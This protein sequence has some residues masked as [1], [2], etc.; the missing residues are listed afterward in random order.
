MIAQ[1]QITQPVFPLSIPPKFILR[2]DLTLEIRSVIV[3]QAYMAQVQNT[4]GV[5]TEL[6][7][8]YNVSRTFIYSLL[9]TFKTEFAH[10]FFPKEAPASLSREEVEARI[11]SYRFEGRCS[12]DAISTL[13]NR[14]D[15][16]FSSQGAVSEFLTRTGELLPNTLENESEAVRLAVFANDEVFTKSQP[17]LITIEPVSSAILRIELADNRKG[18]QW[19]KHYDDI[20][21][22]GFNPKLLTSDAGVG[23]CSANEAKFKGTPWQLDTFHSVAHRLGDWDRKLE[24]AIESTINYATD[25]E[26]KLASAKSDPVINKRLNLCFEADKAVEKARE[27]HENFGYLYREII[28]Q[29]NTF[30]STGNLR[31]HDHAKSTIEAALDLMEELVHKA[32]N[33][34]IASVRKALPDFLTY[35]AEAEIAVKNCQ[36]LTDNKDALTA[37]YLA[38]Q[39]DKAVIKSKQTDRKHSAIEQ[40]DFYL[41]LAMLFIGDKETG[42]KLKENV[43][44]ELNQIIQ[45]SSMVECINSLLRPYLN[46]LRNQVTQEFLNTFMFYHNHRRYHAGKRKGKTPMEMLT[47]KEQKEDWITLLQK[48]VKEKEFALLA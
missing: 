5:I 31:K 26:D 8:E 36:K 35:F 42:I 30:D 14:D 25:R 22:N 21:D 12:I 37:L 40:R 32:I 9:D 27:L 41:E 10:L 7:R 45:A 2:Q 34:D 6:A 44:A 15:M 46:N 33:K 4:W 13:M 47:G 24:K 20:L 18:E 48:K 1:I 39:W 17:I 43:Y 29:L 19:G 11:L 38:W 28:H 23:I 16:P 3:F